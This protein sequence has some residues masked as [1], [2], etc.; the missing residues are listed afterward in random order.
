M[1]LVTSFCLSVM[2]VFCCNVCYGQSKSSFLAIIPKPIEVASLK[3]AFIITSSTAIVCNDSLLTPSSAL[4]RFYIQKEGIQTPVVKKDSSVDNF[5]RFKI[6]TLAVA[7]A[8]GY[9]LLVNKHSIDISCRDAGGVIYA[10]QTLRQLWQ[11]QKDGSLSVAGC[12]INDYPRFGYRGMG[13]D[14][15]RHLFPPSFIKKYIDL[16][17]LYKFNTFHWHLTD[18]QGWRI[19]IKQ[20]PRL[21]SVAAWRNETLVGHKKELPHRFDGKK[22]GGYYSQKEVADIVEYATQR[23]IT[24]L[25]EI[26]MPGHALAALAAYPSLGCTGGPYQTATFWGIFDD[27][28]C[29]GNDSTFV[30]LEHVLDEVMQLFPSKYI[31]IGGDE[32]RK[33]RWK[34]CPKCQQRIKQEGLKDEA[35]LQSYFIERI[36][37]YVNSKGRSIIGWDEITE[38]KLAPNATIMSWRGEEGGILAAKQQHRVIMTPESHLYFDYYQSLYPNEPLA[39]GGY[40]PLSKVYNYEPAAQTGNETINQ[41]IA[42]VEGEAWSEYYQDTGTVLRMVFPRAIALAELAWTSP[43]Q[44]GYDDFLKLLRKQ[45]ELLTRLHVGYSLSFDEVQ[46]QSCI[47][48]NNRLRVSL[49]SS[50]PEAI[51]RYT[52]NGQ[53]P[54]EKSKL[55][56]Q[57]IYVAQSCSL[58]A[59]LFNAQSKLQGRIFE[60]QLYVHKALGAAVSL[61][62]KA[63]EKFDPGADGLVN[64]LCGNN[65]YNNDQWLGFNGNNLEALIS[66]KKM[67]TIRSFDMHFLNYHWQRMWA[68]VSVE[69]FASADGVRFEKLF[70]QNRF[71]INGIN[72]V[73]ARFKPLKAKYL[74]VIAVNKG[75]I[76]QGEYGAGGKA[77]LMVDE[78]IVQ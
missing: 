25:P 69:I 78:M 48:E 16:L 37:A 9:R 3:E 2:F 73:E 29:A 49:Q 45:D 22:Y 41:Y 38:G 62:N 74:K 21:Q 76:P 77:L 8:E 63:V 33:I 20:Y 75:T 36:E 30:F 34:V 51:I 40:T 5:I 27:V 52:I 24:V 4:L 50:L 71:P 13:L 32:C 6:D 19:E 35:E 39:A 18:D 47:V 61:T 65:R 23:N 66:L 11:L 55:Y 7:K 42:G 70:V 1:R 58:K 54:S 46:M 67:E 14:V 56:D 28:Y 10:I 57:P 17:A 12:Y 72:T 44:R 26:E 15:S 31:H 60:Q 68:P 53:V 43:K 64:G 59:C